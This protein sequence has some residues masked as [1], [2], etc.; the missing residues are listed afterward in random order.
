[1]EKME[2]FVSNHILIFDPTNENNEKTFYE[3]FIDEETGEIIKIERKESDYSDKKIKKEIDIEKKL[4]RAIQRK[5]KDMKF[6]I[7]VG[8]PPYDIGQSEIHLKIMD[9]ILHFC[10][11]KLNFILPSKPIT[12]QLKPKWYNM[13]KNAVCNNID[14][15]PK[16]M[17]KDTNMEDIAIYYCDRHETPENYCKKL[18]VNNI[19]YNMIDN[20][21]HK[22]FLDKI[23]I[24]E[25]LDIDYMFVNKHYYEE[26]YNNFLTTAKNDCYYL[27]VNRANGSLGAHWISGELKKVDIL[28]KEEELEF[29]KKHTAVKNIIECPTKEYGEN[30]KNLMING[31]VLRYSLWLLQ[32]NQGIY[33]PEFKYVP[34]VDYTNIH[35]DVELLITCEFTPDEIEKVMKYLEDFDFKQNRNDIVR[36]YTSHKVEIDSE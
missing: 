36:S 20:E 32:K 24:I 9:T 35:N 2:N 12:Q 21:A 17:F 34:D 6:D 31:F 16:E 7:V 28:T 4:E 11:D 22:L 30:L 19:I 18:D 10:K 5:W 1:M 15:I 29:C 14:V 33:G 25:H 3:E 13:F 8:N 26:N 23:G 27:N